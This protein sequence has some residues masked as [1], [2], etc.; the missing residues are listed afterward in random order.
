MFDSRAAPVQII[1]LVG[2]T[3]VF[4]SQLTVVATISRVVRGISKNFHLDDSLTF[5][6]TFD[7]VIW[8]VAEDEVDCAFQ[9]SY[10]PV[11]S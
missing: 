2:F 3:P 10:G 8:R 11:K 9:C 5:L 6:K 4:K 7:T 1:V